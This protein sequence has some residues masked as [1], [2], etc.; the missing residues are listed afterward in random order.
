[1]E[2]SQRTASVWLAVIGEVPG[3][4]RLEVGE[5]GSQPVA[6]PWT[7]FSTRGQV[8]VRAQ[9]ITVTGLQPDRR[10]GL[11]LLEGTTLRA[12]ATTKTLPAALPS[13]GQ[14]P[15]TWLLGSCFGRLSDELGA[16][17]ATVHRLPAT[18][19]PDATLLVGDQVYLD[20]PFA[21]FLTAVITG[22]ELRAALLGTY[23]ATW[24]QDGPGVGFAQVL[25]QGATYFAADDHE[26]WNNAPSRSPAVMNS[27]FSDHREEF[28]STATTLYELFQT[29]AR[30]ARIDIG[31]LSV[32]VVETRLDRTADRQRLM[33]EPR[34]REL[35]GWVAGL[36]GPGVLVL[37]QPILASRAG[38]RGH[39]LDW[40]L[41]D[42]RHYDDL[43]R[44]VQ[45]SAHDVVVLTGDVHYGRVAGCRLPSG[46]QLIE[47]IAS[48]FALVDARLKREWHGPPGRFPDAA[49]PGTTACGVWV[50]VDYREAR[51]H[52]A[53]IGFSDGGGRVRMEV[54]AWPI[55]APALALTPGSAYSVDLH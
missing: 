41:P 37:G 4:L 27:W 2:A 7:T 54:Q 40:A 24:G 6:G 10:Y 43:A 5:A 34:M 38:W 50:D 47:V 33:Q 11:R 31:R 18:Y 52:F 3:S 51:D 44:A 30:S 48:P 15:F 32:L 14:R 49:I 39:L 53:T 19:R 42:F 12:S 25:R 13:L 17:G 46:A 28:L 26:L 16:V 45:R 36:Q 1:M 23:L 20:A 9:R 55:S 8:R 35:E 29:P 22:E 21:R